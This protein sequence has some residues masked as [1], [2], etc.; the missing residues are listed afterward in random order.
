MAEIFPVITG[1]R[2][3]LRCRSP[4][5][6]PQMFFPQVLPYD[7]IQSGPGL[8]PDWPLADQKEARIG[9]RLKTS[10]NQPYFG[11]RTK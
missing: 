11:N 8:S 5:P 9:L 1:S 3:G 2:P 4:H 6:S 10:P 7:L